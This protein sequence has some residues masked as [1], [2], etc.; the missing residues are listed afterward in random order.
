[1]KRCSISTQPVQTVSTHV[2]PEHLAHSAVLAA[3]RN[4]EPLA[5]LIARAVRRELTEPT[6]RR[7]QIRPAQTRIG[8]GTSCGPACPG[9]PPS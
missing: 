1:M 3:R 2:L 6:C 5:D 8:T 9:T 4:G 7:C